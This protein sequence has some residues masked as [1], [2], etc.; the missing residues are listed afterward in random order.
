MINKNFI[1]IFGNNLSIATELDLDLKKRPEELDYEIFYKIA[2][3]Y[4]KLFS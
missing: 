1:K 3:E 4:E 2:V